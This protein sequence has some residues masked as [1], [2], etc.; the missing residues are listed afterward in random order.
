MGEVG[1]CSA[2]AAGFVVGVCVDWE[3][4]G[5]EGE[6]EEGGEEGGE[7]HFGDGGAADGCSLYTVF[8]RLG[9]S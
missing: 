8:Q 4:Q 9:S 7:M 1:S 3:E 5:G 2:E 6:E